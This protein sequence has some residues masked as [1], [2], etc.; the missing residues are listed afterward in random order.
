MS[1]LCFVMADLIRHLMLSTVFQY[2]MRS[3]V[4]PGMTGQYILIHLLIGETG[5]KD[6]AFRL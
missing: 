2:R 4:K 1:K 6:I 5:K 3:R